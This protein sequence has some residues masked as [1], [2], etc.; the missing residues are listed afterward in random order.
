MT[1][2]VFGDQGRVV[3]RIARDLFPDGD[4]ATWA[5]AVAVMS[6]EGFPSAGVRRIRDVTPSAQQYRIGGG[7]ASINGTRILD[8]V[9]PEEGVQE[10][11]LTPAQSIASGNLDDLTPDDFGQVTP[12]KL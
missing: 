11:M 4:P 7:D 2:L 12:L 6:Q 3:V 8:L 1:T 9:W 10:Q 5:Y